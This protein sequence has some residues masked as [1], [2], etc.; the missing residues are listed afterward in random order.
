MS[1][2]AGMAFIEQGAS[3]WVIDSTSKTGMKLYEHL[4]PHVSVK[5]EWLTTVE[6]LKSNIRVV[7]GGSANSFGGMGALLVP[8]GFTI[9]TVLANKENVLFYGLQLIDN[10]EVLTVHSDQVDLLMMEYDYT[11]IY[12]KDFLMQEH[13]GG[14][15]FNNGGDL[16]VNN[17]TISNNVADGTLGNGG[18]LHVKTGTATVLLST[19]SANS[20]L[21]NGGGLYNNATLSVNA[22]TV[23]NNEATVNGGGIANNNTLSVTLKNSIVATN[24]AAAGFDLSNNTGTFVS[25]G[26]N[27]IGQDDSNVF[28]NQATDIEGTASVIIDPLLGALGD[29]GGDT[30]THALLEGSP[31]YNMGDPADMFDDQTDNAV[32]G[33]RRDIGAYESQTVLGIEDIT[34]SN[35]KKSMIYPNPSNNGMINIAF[36]ADGEVSASMIEV[37][38]GKMVKQMQL[39]NMSNQISLSDFSTGVYIVQLVSNDF[40]ETHRLIIGR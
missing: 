12:K 22:S 2:D 7:A 1:T 9:P 19:F 23:A 27:L 25:N 29:N 3:N 30:F 11:A 16:V 35:S 26:Y 13:G 34:F 32:F 40:T 15:I 39:S 8:D 6:A 14:G 31:A 33:G 24:T 36:A 5:A 18:G 4:P 20:T 38:S 37:G 10:G 28:P 21:N 17:S